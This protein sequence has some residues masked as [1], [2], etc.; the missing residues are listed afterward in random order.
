MKFCFNKLECTSE[1]YKTEDV[2]LAIENAVFLTNP[3]NEYAFSFLAR[4]YNSLATG[5]REYL[6]STSYSRYPQTRMLEGSDT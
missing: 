2:L 3:M 4:H 1:D 5:L 6:M